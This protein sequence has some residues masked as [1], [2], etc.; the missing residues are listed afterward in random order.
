[1]AIF[2]NKMGRLY[3]CHAIAAE[4]A[5]LAKPAEAISGE[6]RIKKWGQFYFSGSASR[7]EDGR[8]IELTP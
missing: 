6:A 1:M 8:K 3:F 2:P 5:R 4:I 7:G